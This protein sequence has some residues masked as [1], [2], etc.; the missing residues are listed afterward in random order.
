MIDSC[1]GAIEKACQLIAARDLAGASKVI[2]TDYPFCPLQKSR[3]SYTPGIM[4]R[5]FARDGFVDRY[6][7]GRLVFPGALRLLS[8]YLPAEFPYHKNGSKRSA[9]APSVSWPES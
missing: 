5:V 6:R 4:T 1:V 7:G 9:L 8:H 2:A 3:R